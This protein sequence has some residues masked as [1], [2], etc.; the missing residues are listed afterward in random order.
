MENLSAF[1]ANDIR[2]E[3]RKNIDEK[4]VYK[5]GR[6]LV[7]F[8]NCKN[9]IVGRDMRTSSLSLTKSIINGI[10]D[11]GCNV[12]EIGLVDS[13]ALYFATGFYNK[14]GVM[15]TASHN[16]AK[17]NG[18]KIIKPGAIPISEL[19]GLIKVKDILQSEKF[20][21]SK[22]KGR[23]SK[24]NLIKKYREHIFSFIDINKIKKM[25][26]VIDGGNGMAGKMVP[27]I[28]KNLP[29]II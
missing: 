20:Y 19:N 22:M 29:L 18:M 4:L 2:G 8:L 21:D 1:K 16:P 12:I 7:E 9:I 14:P 15:I 26:V 23:V 24:L 17:Y 6:A 5:I 28:Y 3:Y 10:I 25:K 11:S 13:P 27:T